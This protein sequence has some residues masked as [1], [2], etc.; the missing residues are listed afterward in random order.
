MWIHELV[1][2]EQLVVSPIVS[3]VENQRRGRRLLHS[4][5]Q[6]LPTVTTKRTRLYMQTVI[7]NII[8]QLMMDDGT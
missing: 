7:Y 8:M 4:K 6:H 3:V 1:L 2:K 5:V